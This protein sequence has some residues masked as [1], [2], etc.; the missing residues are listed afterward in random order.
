M[1]P[2]FTIKFAGVSRVL[3]AVRRLVAA[4]GRLICGRYQRIH[5]SYGYSCYNHSAKNFTTKIFVCQAPR[6][7]L[8][9]L[10]QP[11]VG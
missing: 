3:A 10:D 2:N 4:T 9:G 6:L 5:G 1:A 11:L 7:P 8:V